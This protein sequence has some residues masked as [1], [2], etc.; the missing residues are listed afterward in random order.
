[1]AGESEVVT[2]PKLLRCFY[3]TKAQLDALTGLKLEDLGYG[4]D[5]Q[6]LYRWSGA[7]WQAITFDPPW[8][9]EETLSPA[10]VTT[11]SSSSPLAS[12]TLW[13]VVFDCKFDAGGA[14]EQTFDIRFNDDAGPNYG[15]RYMDNTAIITA[16]GENQLQI[17]TNVRHATEEAH[18]MGELL[19]SGLGGLVVGNSLAVAAKIAMISEKYNILVN[20]RWSCDNH[21]VTKM[22]FLGVSYTGKIQLYYLD[23]P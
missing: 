13:K 20:G 5:T 21:H 6:L 14:G 7:A 1:M 9:L 8:I 23:I 15:R 19:F 3:L 10:G 17:L 18:F 11:I 4:T 12:H 2:I 16:T 22:T